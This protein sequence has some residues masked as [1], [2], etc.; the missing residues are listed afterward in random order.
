LPVF[1]KRTTLRKEVY[2]QVAGRWSELGLSG[3]APTVR[4]FEQEQT[5]TR[6]HEEGTFEPGAAPSM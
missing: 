1:S 6:Y 2:D 3:D 4:A 5:R